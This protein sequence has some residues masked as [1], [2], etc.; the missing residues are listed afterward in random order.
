MSFFEIVKPGTHIDFL[1][2]RKVA[3]AVS[4]G[5]IVLG[6]AAVPLRGFRLGVDFAG[7]TELQVRFPDGGAIDEGQVRAVV[8]GLGIE[9]ASV[10]RYG[11]PSN[12]EFLVKFANAPRVEAG[13]PLAA[14]PAL[15]PVSAGADAEAVDEA[16]AAQ[17]AEELGGEVAAEE[18]LAGLAEVAPA[19]EATAQGDQVTAVVEALEASLGSVEVERAE[20]VGPKVGEELRRA[21]LQSLLWACILILGYIWFRFSFRFA[22]GAVVALVHDVLITGGIWVLLGLE[23]DLRVLAALLAIVGYSLNDT[24]IVFDRIRENMELRTKRDLNEVLNLSVNQ[25]LSRTLLTSG[26]TLLALLSLLVVGGEVIQPFAL[27]MAIGVLVGTYSSIYVAAPTL[28]LL[29]NWLGRD[30]KA[31]AAA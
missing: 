8:S 16:A 26:T 22:P 2:R 10:V 14:E 25:T 30:E 7:G 12:A 15:D 20:F 9:N 18:A 19:L 31:R 3:A 28:L 21:G 24:I 13:A 23:F 11:D 4:V 29:E 6:L 5:L 17:V 1:S 27:A